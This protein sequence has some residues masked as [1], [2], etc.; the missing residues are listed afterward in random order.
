MFTSDWQDQLGKLP[1]SDK[2]LTDV[3]IVELK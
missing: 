2:Y 3:F 1:G